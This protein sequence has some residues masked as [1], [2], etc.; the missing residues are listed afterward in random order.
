VRDGLVLLD[1]VTPANVT[2]GLQW[3]Y[4]QAYVALYRGALDQ[5]RRLAGPHAEH[6]VPRWRKRFANLLAILAEADGAAATVVDVDDRQQQQAQLAATEASFDFEIVGDA[7]VVSHVNLAAAQLNFYKMDI[8]LLFSRQPFMQDQSDRFAIVQPNV[9]RTLALAGEGPVQVELPAEL[10]SANTIVELLAGGVRRSKANYAHDLA[11]RVIEPY[12]QLRVHERSSGRALARAYVKVYARKAGGGVDFYKDGYT[13][14]RGAFDYASLSTN[15]LDSVER[16][17][18]LV[19]ADD[20][21]AL[22][23]EAAPPQR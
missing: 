1:R 7:I 6:P 3:D 16:F 19:H 10:R 5:A 15:E 20:R 9:S 14:L 11:V 23:R 22:I 2:G 8:E 17:A 12:G 13:D 18:I 4:L 21:G